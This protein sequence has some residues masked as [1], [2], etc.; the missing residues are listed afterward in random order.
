MKALGRLTLLDIGLIAALILTGVLWYMSSSS[1]SSRGSLEDVDLTA[2]GTAMESL[3]DAL[4]TGSLQAT[5]AAIQVAAEIAE[6]ANDGA[7]DN[8][9][10]FAD[11][12]QGVDL[13][14][15]DLAFGEVGPVALRSRL[16]EDFY[17]T[18]LLTLSYPPFPIG[19]PESGA[20][21]THANV[22][23]PNEPI[24]QYWG[25]TRWSL[26]ADIPESAGEADIAI[27]EIDLTGKLMLADDGEAMQLA[28]VFLG[29]LAEYDIAGI[30]GF[31]T[32]D[33]DELASLTGTIVS[34]QPGTIVMALDPN[35]RAENVRLLR[36]ADE[37]GLSIELAGDRGLI[38]R[39]EVGDS[40][41]SV[42]NAGLAATP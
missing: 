30:G 28:L 40:G 38:L 2:W 10:L 6:P 7:A 9:R 23:L 22:V 18:V 15:A 41:R 34:A 20:E 25:T 5:R 13:T 31:W 17:L 24:R 14:A 4:G 12:L 1:D 11:S 39:F 19:D 8:L 27:P 32:S 37:V 29:P 35:A 26:P 16:F 33:G 3:S 21:W 42:I 36:N